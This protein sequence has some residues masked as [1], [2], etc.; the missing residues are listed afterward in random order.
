MATKNHSTDQDP[1][2]LVNVIK[3]TMDE[4]P[5]DIVAIEQEAAKAF[6]WLEEIFK[7]IEE[8]AGTSKK[9]SFYLALERISKLAGTGRQIAFDFGQLM[10]NRHESMTMALIAAGI[11]TRGL[12]GE[13]QHG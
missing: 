3:S 6:S 10:E 8:S 5:L 2:A 4:H 9:D 7:I 11:E 13:V 1:K 12:L